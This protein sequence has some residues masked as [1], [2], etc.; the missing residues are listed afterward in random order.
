MSIHTFLLLAKVIADDIILVRQ[1]RPPL[2]DGWQHVLV[3]GE[4]HEEG[5]GD[6]PHTDGEICHHLQVVD[7]KLNPL[8][9]IQNCSLPH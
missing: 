8:S 3:G 1:Q 5:E 6:Q 7:V 2:V 4:R 9:S